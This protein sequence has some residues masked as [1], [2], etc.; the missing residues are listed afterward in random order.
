LAGCSAAPDLPGGTP[1]PSQTD[2]PSDQNA[3]AVP[4]VGERRTVSS[5]V[6]DYEQQ[7]YEPLAKKFTAE[8]PN[9]TIAL[10]SLDDMMNVPQHQQDTPDGPLSQLRWIVSGADTAPPFALTPEAFG[11]GLMLDLAPL[12]D[13]D[14]AFKRD[15][16][17]P[18]AL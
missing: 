12:M 17:L 16:F 2:A 3:T 18:G 8:H 5:A 6:W 11:S 7:R 10:V 14:S 15:D 4:G 1:P 13:A 9:I